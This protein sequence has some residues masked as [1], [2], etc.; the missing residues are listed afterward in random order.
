[1]WGQLLHADEI[2]ADRLRIWNRYYDALGP[3]ADAGEIQLPYIPDECV[4]NAHMFYIKCKNLD[5]RT[6]YIKYMRDNDILCV[7]HY[8]P[9]HSAPAG[10]RFG[11]FCGE[12]EYTTSHADRLVRLP[13]Y[14][15]MTHDDQE[16]VIR[17]TLEF[18]R[19]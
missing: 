13:L 11:T 9:L 14:Y 1:M 6:K 4:H 2:Q 5:V 10:I 7:F 3:V 19:G 17:K 18:F 15:G 8:V 12:D 16:K